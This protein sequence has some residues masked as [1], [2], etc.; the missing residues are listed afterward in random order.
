MITKT[1]DTLK[2]NLNITIPTELKELQLGQLITMQTT[3]AMTDLD[4]IHILSGIPVKDLK[5]I[6]NYNDLQQF[7]EHVSILVSQIKSLYNNVRI[8]KHVKIFFNNSEVTVPVMK[9][10]SIEPAG[11]F[12]AARDIIADEIKSHIDQ[13]G[14]EHWQEHFN[15]SLQA[16]CQILAH[17]FYCPVSHAPYD[18]YQASLFEE[19]VK[20]LPVTDALPIARYFF[21]SYPNLSKQKTN[22][23]Q[24]L[25]RRWNNGQVLKSLS[26]F[27]LSTRSTHWQG[28]MSPNGQPL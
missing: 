18:E 17:Y 1:L 16:C 14:E 4:A 19:Q 8:P 2:G 9:N 10:L 22:F 12:M 6:R 28:A 15:P 20:L 13:H 7:N 23:W 5:Q 25:L 11:A 26:G 21:L 24:R 27:A 3:T